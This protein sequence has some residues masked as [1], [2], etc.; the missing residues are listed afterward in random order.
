MLVDLQICNRLSADNNVRRDDIVAE[1]DPELFMLIDYSSYIGQMR[2]LFVV[3][4]VSAQREIP[5]PGA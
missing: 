2:V 1:D 3:T 4:D 5:F